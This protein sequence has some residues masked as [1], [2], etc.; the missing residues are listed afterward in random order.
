MK[1]Y[2]ELVREIESQ[3]ENETI[4]GGQRL[5]SIREMSDQFAC[6]KSTVIKAYMELERLHLIYSVPQSGYYAVVK[7]PESEQMRNRTMIDFTLASPDPGLFP[8]L[9]FQHCLNKAIDM[10]RNHLFSYGVSPGLPSLL[11]V[12]SKHL[13]NDQ[14]FARP[15]QL[16]IT[17]GIQQALSILTA[18]PF[19]NGKRTVL[20]EQPSYHLFIQLLQTQGIP[21]QGIAR[22]EQGIDLDQLE[23]WFR[24]G[25]IKLFYTMPRFHNPLGTSFTEKTKKAIAELAERYGVYVVEDDYLADLEKDTKADPIY[26]YRASHVIYLRSFS[27]ILFPGLRLGLAVLPQELQATFNLY[28]QLSDIDSSMLSQAALEIYL[29]NGMFDRRKHKI[30]TSYHNRMSLLN[31]AL[32][33]HNDLNDVRYAAVRYGVHTHMTFAKSL[34]IQT[35]LDRLRKRNILLKKLDQCFIDAFEKT[36]MLKLSISGVEE[37]RIDEGVRAIFEE[38]R[39]M[40]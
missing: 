1:K 17:S 34:P 5:P 10:Y 40:I 16:T 6:S 29:Q 39:R 27:K 3:L 22:T 23:S 13:A 35:L 30:V 18:M 4:R 31:R 36:P 28:K 24:T 25:E 26:A 32:E 21:V 15:D 37:A 33:K 14:V 19:P 8:Y 11:Q 12:L 2:I 20:M 9:D 7:K 38:I